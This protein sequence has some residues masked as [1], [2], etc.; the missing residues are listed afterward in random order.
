MV[1]DPAQA[2]D[3]K[4]GAT[5][6]SEISFALSN[7]GYCD[8]N[9]T[10]D[11]ENFLIV[12]VGDIAHSK[13]EFF[14]MHS[15]GIDRLID[16]YE[17]YLDLINAAQWCFDACRSTTRD[18]V[19]AFLYLGIA[20][21]ALLGSKGGSAN[22]TSTLG[23]RLAYLISQ[24]REEREEILGDFKRFYQV[25]SKV[26]H[27]RLAWLDESETEAFEWGLRAFKKAFEKELELI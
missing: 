11:E 3:F 18:P 6:D 19:K 15:T 5:L 12:D 21:D 8:W 17:D 24:T 2:S 14:R 26:V 20:W 27:G 13:K 4:E 23:D 16:S 10:V 7:H 25:R 9:F 22:I 1:F